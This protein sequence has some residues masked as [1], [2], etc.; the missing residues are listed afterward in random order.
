MRGLTAAAVASAD[1]GSPASPPAPA[2]AGLEEV[3]RFI[4][5]VSKVVQV[6]R[7]ITRERARAGERE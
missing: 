1:A 6:S 7:E 4:A 2:G 5:D 3:E